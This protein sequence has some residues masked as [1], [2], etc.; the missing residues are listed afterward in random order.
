[1]QSGGQIKGIGHQKLNEVTLE[2]ELHRKANVSK[3]WGLDVS[4]RWRED[5]EYPSTVIS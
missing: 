1:V 2:A 3:R 4:W 5:A